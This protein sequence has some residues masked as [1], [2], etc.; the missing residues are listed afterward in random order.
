MELLYNP[1]VMPEAEIKATFVARQRLIDE[2]VSLIER[3]PE[4]AGMQHVVIIAPRGMGK[5]TVLLMVKFAIKDRGLAERWQAVKFPEESYGVNDLADFWIEVLNLLAAETND[6]GL[7]QRA[8]S[9]KTRYPNSDDLQE[10]ALAAIKDWR[11]K[12]GK[13]LV[14]LTDNL[15]QILKQINDERDNAR[16]RDVLMNDDTVMLV[17]GA[18]TFFKEAR[19]YDQPLYNFFKIYDLADLKFEQIQELLRR[20]AERDQIPNFKEVLQANASRLRALEYFTGGNPRLVL[21]LYRVVTQSD[22]TEV[23]RGLEKLLDEVTPYYKAKIESLPV[24]QQ[25]ILDHIARVSGKTSEGVTPSAIAAAVRLSANQVSAQLKRLSENGY[26]RAANLRGRSSYYTLSE[27]L[28]ALWHQM[29]FGRE[30]RERMQWLLNFLRVLYTGEERGVESE[31]LTAR[32]REYLSAGR[33]YEAR[34]V[35]EHQRY[36]A[37]VMEGTPARANA[38][39]H[40][41][42]GYLEIKDAETVKNELLA[43]VKLESLSQETLHKLQEAGCLSEEQVIRATATKL[44]PA[45]TQQEKEFAEAMASAALSYF[46]GNPKEAL[47]YLDQALKIKPEDDTAWNNRGVALGYLGRYEEAI[48]SYDQALKIKPDKDKAWYNRGIVYLKKFIKLAQAGAFEL[49]IQDWNEASKSGRKEENQDWPNELSE[50]LLSVA[51]LGQLSFVRQLI[52][53]SDLEE[54]LFPLAR[55]IDYLL[56]GHEALIEKLSPE[57]RGIVEEVVAKLRPVTGNPVQQAKWEA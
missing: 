49:A 3:Q 13:R 16:L 42:R 51:R 4:G 8:E 7:G 55:A 31:R 30:T 40:V 35:L 14:L 23:R 19:A 34:D 33:L 20:R 1:D 9:L 47:Q 25:K 5:T 21:M 57:V 54:R 28:Y 41:I 24:Q 50:A 12:H 53:G 39:E 29:R 10:A 22:I 45:V 48:A 15:D 27:P 46:G 37:E 2:L 36:L 18:T 38:V 52:A 26:V 11:R 43:T 32:F 44:P 56:T 17:G 6:A